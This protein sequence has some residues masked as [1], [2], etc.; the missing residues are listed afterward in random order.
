MLTYLTPN[1]A[2]ETICLLF[3]I[4]CLIADKNLVWRSMV[5]YILI[6]CVSEIAG[7][8]WGIKSHNNNWIYNIFIICEAGFTLLMFNE[9]LRK[10]I[11]STALIISGAIVFVGLYITG[12]VQ[13]GFLIYNNFTYTVMS[14]IYSLYAL[15]FC[16]LLLKASSYRN[17]KF[18]PEFWWATGVLFF[19]F[20]NTACNLFDDKLENIMVTST[21]N[22]NYVIFAALNILMYGCW[23]YSFICKRWLA[24]RSEI[25]L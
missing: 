15:Y 23:S 3:S 4:I 11:K 2:I 12:L 16:Y 24:P 18:L 6:T 10:Y 22:L 19:Y 21:K 17:L 7:I 8:Y 1:T 25:L 9:L 5:L 13:H 14:I 20:A